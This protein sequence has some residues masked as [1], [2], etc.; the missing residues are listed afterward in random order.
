MTQRSTLA[1]L[2]TESASGVLVALAALAA[3]LCANSPLAAAYYRLIDTPFSIQLG[4]FSE[5]HTV[6]LWVKEGLMAIF[7]FVVGMEIKLEVRRGELANPRK[8]ALPILAA[9]GGMIVPALIYSAINSGAGSDANGWVVPTGT[10]IALALTALAAVSRGLPGSLRIFLLTLAIANDL[11]VVGLIAALF[12]EG[13]R[14]WE[15]LGAG[16]ALGCMALLGRW[17]QAPYLF[18]A[19][20]FIVVWGFTVKSGVSTS[21]AGLAA[22]L[23]I[24]LTARRHSQEGVLK[25]F[26]EGLHPYVAFGVLP[27]FA[28]VSA[29]FSFSSLPLH[30]LIAP[31]PL[32]IAAGLFF[33]KQ[34][35]ILG[36]AF[37]AVALK[38]ARKPTSATWLELY[39]AS[40]LC[41][42]GFT[43]SL[44]VAALA[45]PR[46]DAVAL[47]EV[48]L[49]V[50][51]ASL[52][53]ALV[54]VLILGYARRRR[55]ERGADNPPSL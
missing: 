42:C 46:A 33:G 12:T 21:V 14:P 18:Y 44:Y 22:A 36:A 10:D 2:K 29:G 20:G 19:V 24:P 13:F 23:T 8:L 5:T 41:G 45:F 52:F 31:I 11:V 30:T 9:L 17:R 16:I 40:V 26:L 34:I 51:M 15:L 1:F 43:M 55:A 50:V 53:S 3:I 28:F 27:L 35:G 38:L 47:A 49:G 37:A 54:G 48:R 39:G 32:G 6:L 25:Q 4:A 7:F